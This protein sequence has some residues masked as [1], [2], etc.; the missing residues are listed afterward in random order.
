MGWFR[1]VWKNVASRYA[2][3]GQTP[4]IC[5]KLKGKKQLGGEKCAVKG[6]KERQN[7]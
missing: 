4:V 1:Q 5:L 6:R 7:F 2:M 3:P